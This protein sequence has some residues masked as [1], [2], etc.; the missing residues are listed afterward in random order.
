MSETAVT[1]YYIV[2]FDDEAAGW[3]EIERI[4]EDD[5][6]ESV[7]YSTRLVKESDGILK[8]IFAVEDYWYRGEYQISN[9]SVYDKSDNAESR[10]YGYSVRLVRDVE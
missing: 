6:E 2:I 7:Y 1:I 3:I 9:I 5:N 4:K 8:G 10:S